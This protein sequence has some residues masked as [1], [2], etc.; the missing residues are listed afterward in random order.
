MELHFD[1]KVCVVVEFKLQIFLVCNKQKKHRIFIPEISL[2]TWK[3]NWPSFDLIQTSF[4]RLSYVSAEN[5]KTGP[6]KHWG[7]F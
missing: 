1:N 7:N 2:K 5:S 6:K 4:S 3:W